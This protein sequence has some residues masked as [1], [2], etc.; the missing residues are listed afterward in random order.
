MLQHS[1]PE[2][3][4]ADFTYCV[5]VGRDMQQTMRF[6]RKILSNTHSRLDHDAD[7][8]PF[9]KSDNRDLA[10]AGD[11]ITVQSVWMFML[12]GVFRE[13][14][15]IFNRM[16]KREAGERQKQEDRVEGFAASSVALKPCDHGGRKRNRTPSP[17][18]CEKRQRKSGGT[19]LVE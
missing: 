2:G 5:A 13:D 16:L 14:P 11:D 15:S 3:R 19:S 17:S 18:N 6:V 7:T 9:M 1:T 4:V 8:W 12:K 10:D